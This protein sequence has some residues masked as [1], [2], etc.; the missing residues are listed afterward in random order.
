MTIVGN[1]MESNAFLIPR[2]GGVIIKNPDRSTG[3]YNFSLEELKSI[4]SIFITQLRGL[5]G[6]HDV[7]TEAKH[8]LVFIFSF[9]HIF[10]IM[11]F[12][13]FFNYRM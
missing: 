4:M 5:L 8:A 10:K 3:T 2:W 6:V 12:I 9:I 7:W 1:I 13:F 11:K